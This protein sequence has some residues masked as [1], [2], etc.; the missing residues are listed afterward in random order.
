MTSGD[1]R[2]LD[3]IDSK[4]FAVKI[5]L[6]QVHLDFNGNGTIEESESLLKSLSAVLGRRSRAQAE[7]DLVIQFDRADAVWLKG[8]THFLSGVLDI[9][10]A[11]DWRPV[12]N[13]CAHLL[14]QNPDPYPEFQIWARPDRNVSQWADIIATVHDMRLELTDDDAWSRARKEFQSMISTS[15][16]C[17]E[18]VLAE[19]D[20]D[21]EWLPSPTQSGPREST[22]TQVQVD[23]WMKVLDEL[24]A[25]I[26]GDKLM[27][28]W[29][30]KPGSGI[31][32]D[33]LVD[34]PPELDLV[35]WVQGS[36][37]IPF[38][39]EGPVSDQ[40]TWVYTVCDLEQL[41]KNAD[42]PEELPQSSQERARL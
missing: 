3:K 23:A 19:T 26:Q 20:N 28:H 31:N 1:K 40:A 6:S 16:I 33:K 42:I 15:R 11:Y 13:Q 14:L 8:Y 2:T 24:E 7:E 17:W 32:V 39:E 35:L 25:I 18:Y 5:N 29:R 37:L 41:T 27:P 36:A 4:E 10:L 9:L 12:W 30:V 38:I 34:S 22:I 21:L